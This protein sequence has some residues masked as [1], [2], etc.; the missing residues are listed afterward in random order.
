MA[1]YADVSR[2]RWRR[3]V[4]VNATID[5]GSLVCWVQ[6]NSTLAMV[7]TRAVLKTAIH[8]TRKL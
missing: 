2:I 4:S 7:S 1:L 6:K 3:I 5:M 8:R